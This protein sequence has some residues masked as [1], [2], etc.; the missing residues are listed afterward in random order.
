[1][2]ILKFIGYVAGFCGGGLVL[3]VIT[4]GCIEGFKKIRNRLQRS[5]VENIPSPFNKYGSFKHME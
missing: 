2:N 5:S 1:M 3:L 4:A